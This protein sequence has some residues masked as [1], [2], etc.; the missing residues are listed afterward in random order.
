MTTAPPDRHA[1][2][3]LRRKG[4]ICLVVAL[5]AAVMFATA[6]KL[7]MAATGTAIM[8]VVAIWLWRRPEPAPRA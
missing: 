5:S 8:G 7:W 3:D 2:V 6:P 4:L 1:L